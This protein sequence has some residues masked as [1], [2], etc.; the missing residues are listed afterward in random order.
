VTPLIRKG[1][2]RNTGS[3]AGKENHGRGEMREVDESLEHT[4]YMWSIL[5]FRTFE[6]PPS[7]TPVLLVGCLS[8]V[9]LVKFFKAK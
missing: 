8:H 1:K 4:Q 5:L 6:Q 7:V 2:L 3:Q 9:T